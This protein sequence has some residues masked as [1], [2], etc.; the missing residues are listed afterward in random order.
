MINMG[1]NKRDSG[2]ALTGKICDKRVWA[3]LSNDFTVPDTQPEIRRILAVTE[4]LLPPAKYVGGSSVECNGVVDYRVIYL[5]TDGELWGACYSSEYE[6][7]APVERKDLNTGIG[8]ATLINAVCE[9]SSARVSAG[10]RVNIRSRVLADIRSYGELADGTLVDTEDDSIQRL[11]REAEAACFCTGVSD[12]IEVSEEIGG[13]YED[14][15]VI[16]A[17]ARAYIKELNRGEESI[18]C[19]G[20]MTLMLLVCRE[21][22]RAEQIAKKVAFDGIVELDRPLSNSLCRASCYVTDVKV[23]VEEGKAICTVSA[24][25]SAELAENRRVEYTA[26]AY[27]TERELES[28]T[29]TLDLPVVLVCG[30]GNF[31]QNERLPLCDTSI[32]EGAV[33]VDIFPRATLDGCEYKGRYEMTGR[34]VYTL[35]WEKEG[36]YGAS[37]V[38]LPLKYAFEGKAGEDISCAARGEVISCRGRVDG[39]LLCIDA[40]ISA[41]ATVVGREPIERIRDMSLGDSFEKEKNRM[42]IYYPAEGETAWDVAKKYRVRADSISEEKNYYL[43]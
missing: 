11:G 25:I 24:V 12:V 39:E 21:G 6:L 17:E 1:Q 37:D 20:E 36:E 34:C 43:F 2:G 19:T 35:L 41:E 18:A 30:K 28:E 32:P 23:S 15:R 13:L 3:E 8:A 27:S 38:E 40:E 42:V 10:R 33:L 31:S 22:Q 16:T 26:D 4:R 5:G 14:S 7:E 29:E 9:G